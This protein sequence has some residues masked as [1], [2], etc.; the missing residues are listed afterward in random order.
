[1]VASFSTRSDPSHLSEKLIIF[2]QG[3][4]LRGVCVSL[5][6]RRDWVADWSRNI[7][8]CVCVCVSRGILRS[9]CQEH[10]GPVVHSLRSPA[11]PTRH[12]QSPSHRPHTRVVD[13]LIGLRVTNAPGNKSDA[14]SVS[15]TLMVSCLGPDI[16]AEPGSSTL[17]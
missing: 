8:L 3:C 16:I 2:T 1:M 5:C 12:Q 14:L 4:R 15:V 11:A 13:H 7:V 17:G 9:I 6:V 10:F